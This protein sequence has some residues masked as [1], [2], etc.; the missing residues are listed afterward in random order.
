MASNPIAN[1]MHVELVL[2]PPSVRSPRGVT[3][4]IG[5]LADVDER[6]VVA[7]VGL[8]VVDVDADAL[9]ADRVG[10]RAQRLGRRRVVDDL[11][12][13]VAHELGGRVV[14]ASVREEVGEGEQHAADAA[15][16]PAAL[17]D[18]RDAPRA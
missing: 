5:S 18:R 6:H 12:D 4:A 2:R 11:A 16:R 13:L 1:T 15:L 9:G 7:V 10:G 3:A 8:V 14:G 17:E